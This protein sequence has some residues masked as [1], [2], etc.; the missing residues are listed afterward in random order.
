LFLVLLR[1]THATLLPFTTLFRSLQPATHDHGDHRGVF[2]G[3]LL[4]VTQVVLVGGGLV[5]ARAGRRRVVRFGL[6]R[7]G[8]RRLRVCLRIRDRKSTRLNSSH[9]SISYAAFSL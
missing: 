2:L 6:G 3:A 5:A 9:V 8:R 7:G 1:P 4:Q